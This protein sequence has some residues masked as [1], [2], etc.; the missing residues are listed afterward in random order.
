MKRLGNK[1]LAWGF[2][3]SLIF[4]LL[5]CSG[6]ASSQEVSLPQPGKP[7][8][9][10]DCV[11]LALRFNPALRSNQALIEAQKARVE[12]A[13]AAYYPQINFNTSYNWNTFNYVSLGGAVRSYT[14]NWTFLDVFSMGPNLNQL[15]YD[16]GRT[17]N[18][19]K[20]NREN[21]KANEQ[22]LVTTKQTVILNVQQAYFGVL[23]TQRLV[24]VAKDVV[25]QT[26]QHLDQAQGF[27]QAGTRPKID[28]T[29]AE[30]DMANAQLALIQANNN[31]DVARVTLNNAIGF[32][33]S[34]TFPV[35]DI[36]GFTPREYQL[37]DIVKTAYGQRPEIEQIKAK[38]RSQEAAIKL[39]QSSYYPILSGN[40]QYIWRGYHMPNDMT[41]DMFFGATL[42]IPI[43]SGFS[44]PNQVS[45]QRANMKN[46][47]SQEEAL[48]L[49]IRLEAEQAYLSQKQATEQ[50]RVT[51]KAV[52]QAQ[53]NYDLASGRYK[54]GVGSPLEITDAE[55]QLANAKANYIQALYNYKVAEAKIERATGANK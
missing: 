3:N 54:V 19:V 18:T 10:N 23:Q 4:L 21:V 34:L 33:Q 37:E 47:V 46:L 36:L 25:S 27:Y 44:S 28:V 26:K 51:E 12:Q 1:G 5:F 2:L 24:E 8:S 50:I 48:K 42:S 41:W 38:Q 15:I 35:E 32:T 31:Y 14:Y 13:L 6:V 39:A 49:N 11:A 45:E 53:E 17:S 29:K 7:L 9:L 30:V 40:A 55:V 22:D 16:F 52:G 20:I 43:F